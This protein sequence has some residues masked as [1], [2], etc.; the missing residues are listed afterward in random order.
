MFS[1]VRYALP[2]PLRAATRYRAEQTISSPFRVPSI[3]T[4]NRLQPTAYA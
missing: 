3:S 1:R 2:A 4:A